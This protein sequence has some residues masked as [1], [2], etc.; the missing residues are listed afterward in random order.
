MMMIVENIPWNVS[1][2]NVIFDEE[3]K[4]NF[5]FGVYRSVSVLF[6]FIL[7]SMQCKICKRFFTILSWPR[8]PID[9]KLL[10]VCQ[11]VYMVN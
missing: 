6:I 11:F 7:A 1:V 3:K 9:L 2:W 4:S 10:Q 5:A 8:W